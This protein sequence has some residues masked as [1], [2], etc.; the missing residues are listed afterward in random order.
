MYFIEIRRL[1][2]SR[3]TQVLLSMPVSPNSTR[4]LSISRSERSPA[5]GTVE[6]S[7]RMPRFDIPAVWL[8]QFSVHCYKL[9]A[10]VASRLDHGGAPIRVTRGPSDMRLLL[11][12]DVPC[13]A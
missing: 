3:V 11:D 13:V 2:A 10:P 8:W 12:L 1:W 9:L 4:F 5:S 6:S 7:R